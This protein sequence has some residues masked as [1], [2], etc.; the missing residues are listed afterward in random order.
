MADNTI[1]FKAEFSSE[2]LEQIR[3]VVREEL[4]AVMKPPVFDASSMTSEELTEHL[5]N[6]K[7]QVQFTHNELTHEQKRSIVEDVKK[8]LAYDIRSSGRVV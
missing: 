6:W 7:S 5:R 3:M 4:Q 2:M 8:A 1:T